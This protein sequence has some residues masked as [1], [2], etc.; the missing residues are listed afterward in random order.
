MILCAVCMCGFACVSVCMCT[1][2]CICVRAFVCVCVCACVRILV[3]WCVSEGL[4]LKKEIETRWTHPGFRRPTKILFEADDDE[5]IDS[6]FTSIVLKIKVP[7]SNESS[8]FTEYASVC[9]KCTA[10]R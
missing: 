7:S 6:I 8:A 3:K 9:V 10:Y 1:C 2:V 4:R 5:S